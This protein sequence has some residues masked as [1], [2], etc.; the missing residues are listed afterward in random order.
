MWSDDQMSAIFRVTS[1]LE[2]RLE[3][4]ESARM[5]LA[6]LNWNSHG[7][8]GWKRVDKW[9]PRARDECVRVLKNV[10][11]KIKVDNTRPRQSI[12]IVAELKVEKATQE[13]ASHSEAITK[14]IEVFDFD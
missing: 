2:I 7:R 12:V 5:L 11:W 3:G 14:I 1:G 10:G 4:D 6:N 9:M 13:I 8:H